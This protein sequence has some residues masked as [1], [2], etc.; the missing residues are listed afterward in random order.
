MIVPYVADDLNAS[1]GN[2]AV[3]TRS[4]GGSGRRKKGIETTGDRAREPV[5]SR[6]PNPLFAGVG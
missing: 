6:R 1:L 4:T 2:S 5:R 3:L